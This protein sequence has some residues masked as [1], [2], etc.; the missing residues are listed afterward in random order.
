MCLAPQDT[1]LL[2]SYGLNC[3]SATTSPWPF[4]CAIGK[5]FTQSHTTIVCFGSVPTLTNS[6]FR[7]LLPKLRA[8]IPWPCTPLRTDNVSSVCESQTQ[9]TGAF[10]ISPDDVTLAHVSTNVQRYQV[11]HHERSM[12]AGGGGASSASWG[13]QREGGK[14]G[15]RGDGKTGRRGDGETG[16][17]EKCEI[18]VFS[19]VATTRLSRCKP[20]LMM[21]SVCSWYVRICSIDTMGDR[22]RRRPSACGVSAC[23]RAC[24]CVCV[25]GQ[26]PKR[27]RDL[28]AHD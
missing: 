27:R 24:A 9:I 25:R 20:K 5:P 21:S 14:A 2:A 12:A 10:P 19:P 23:V 28:R 26:T 3:T 22:G 17:R 4:T 13:R 16:K 8:A 1:I 11:A 6:L 18:I 7:G 15:R